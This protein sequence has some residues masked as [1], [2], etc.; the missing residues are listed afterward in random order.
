MELQLTKLE[1]LFQSTSKYD[2]IHFCKCIV[3]DNIQIHQNTE[4]SLV[5]HYSL[6][7][8]D[9]TFQENFRV[10]QAGQQVETFY[11]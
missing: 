5:L 9:T 4:M 10:C 7:I 1:R 11:V 6:A 8:L 2:L 3:H